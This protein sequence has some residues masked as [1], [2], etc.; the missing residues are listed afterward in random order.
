VTEETQEFV[1]VGQIVKPH[2]I[3]GELVV[4]PTT[5][6][7]EER[8]S[9]GTSLSVR[10]GDQDFSTITVS[11]YRWHQQ[12]ILL[13]TREI[14][15]RNDAEELRDAWLEV[16]VSESSA[17]KFIRE[18]ELIDVEVYDQEGTRR[19][20]V[21][22][23]HLDEMNPLSR[24]D[25]GDESFDFPFSPELVTEFDPDE[26]RLVLNFPDGWRKLIT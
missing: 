22:D 16:Q 1:R 6:R 8:F 15:D 10:N 11:G 20:T 3:D 19:G 12:R 4:Q 23:V 13:E 24:I 7:P 18:H 14:S 25:C 9:E 5:D 26:N 21:V 2:G 17:D